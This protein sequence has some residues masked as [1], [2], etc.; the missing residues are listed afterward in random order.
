MSGQDIN[1]RTK[2]LSKACTKL[3]LVMQQKNLLS[4]HIRNNLL[5]SATQVAVKAGALQFGRS[6]DLFMEKVYEA[7]DAANALIY[8]LEFVEEEKLMDAQLVI[9]LKEEAMIISELFNKA[10]RSVKERMD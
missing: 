10:A 2:T 7:L 3:A 5:F 6:T 1:N 4:E 8:W 9:P